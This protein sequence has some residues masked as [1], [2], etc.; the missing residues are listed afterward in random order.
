MYRRGISVADHSACDYQMDQLQGPLK[1]TQCGL[2][3]LFPVSSVHVRWVTGRS[4]YD[5]FFLLIISLR[6]MSE[7]A[8]GGVVSGGIPIE[9][10]D[11]PTFLC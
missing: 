8:E 10:T 7:A 11:I 9:E 1:E 5:E 2:G 4:V 3:R 6:F